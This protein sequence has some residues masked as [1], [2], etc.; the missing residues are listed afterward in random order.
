MRILARHALIK[1]IFRPRVKENK[2]RKV[3]CKEK[4]TVVPLKKKEKE[5]M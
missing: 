1:K 5:K 2:Q 4:R 3:S